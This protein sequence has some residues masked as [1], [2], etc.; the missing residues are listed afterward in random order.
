M[1]EQG[2]LRKAHQFTGLHLCSVLVVNIV[3][4]VTMVEVVPLI[5]SRIV[6]FGKCCQ[7]VLSNARPNTV[8]CAL[9]DPPT[10]TPAKMLV[11]GG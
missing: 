5:Y 1:Q 10:P 9:L 7:G 8:P 2:I 11:N 4:E 6:I 3:G